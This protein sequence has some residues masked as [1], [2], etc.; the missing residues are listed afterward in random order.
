MPDLI[1]KT[2]L[3]GR[4]PLTL[5]SVTLSEAEAGQM[6]SVAVRK[7]QGGALDAAL[8]AR[9]LAFP[10]PNRFVATEAA[11][12]VWTGRQQAFLIG[13]APDGLAPH[14]ALT[15]LSDGWATLRLEGTDAAG[16][17]ARIVPLD[18][19]DGAFAVGHVARTP[20]NH[21]SSVILRRGAAWYDVL[22]FRSMART[23]WAEAEHAMRAL[24]ARAARG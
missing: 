7:G 17:L 11:C 4:A 2:P 5:G 23:A 15:D 20:F 3:D 1:A 16:V 14:A 8:G 6:T 22:V 13:A 21:M 10:A 9:G 18:L 24:G 12:L 19:R